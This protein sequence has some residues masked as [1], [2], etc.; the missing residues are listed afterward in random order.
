MGAAKA[1]SS[2]GPRALA[3]KSKPTDVERTKGD[4][5]HLRGGLTAALLDSAPG[6][7][8]LDQRVAKF[9]GIYQ[10]E[11][12]DGRA[13][14]RVTGTA[15]EPNF[16]VRVA[17][18]AGQLTADQY[19]ALDELAEDVVYNR[20]F[21]VTTRQDVQLHGVRKADLA[22]A[23][24][25]INEVGLTTLGGCGDVE[26]N[27]V[28]PPAPIRDTG[29]RAL[30]ALASDLAQAL[31]PAT[32]AYREIWLGDTPSDLAGE[33]EPLYGD[34]YLPRKFKTGLALPEDNSVDVHAQD[35]G[36]IGV[37]EAGELTGANVLVGGGAGLT[38]RRPETYARLASP[39]GFVARPYLV[40]TV[41]VVAGM[42]RDYGDRTDRRHSRLKYV[43][44]EWGIEAFRREFE[45]RASFPLEEWVETGPLE[46]RDWLGCHPQGD[47]RWLYG[48][49]V[50]NGRILDDGRRR[51]K[52]ALRTLVTTLRPRVAFTAQ[53]NLLLADLSEEDLPKVEQILDAYR[54]PRPDRLSFVRRHALAC[55][56]LPTCGL[57]LA[58][59]ERVAGEVVDSFERAFAA[60]GLD[61]VPLTLRMTGCPNGCTRPYSA[62]LALVGRK[63]GH[64]D[65]YLGGGLQG[66]RLAELYAESVPLERLVA[67]LEPLLDD[68]QR[69]RLPK[70][71]LGDFYDRCLRRALRRDILTGAKA[72]ASG[73]PSDA[74]PDDA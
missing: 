53:Q 48:V 61:D 39:L 5:R 1:G 52:S 15:R 44:E 73:L 14:A 6:L 37:V 46:H 7:D 64:Y 45:S 12:R 8:H 28:A 36:L 35:V 2:V 59:S 69:R 17:V 54:I 74:R 26:R 63:A 19:L 3:R 56:A 33:E 24:R 65:V 62:D 41:K 50:E 32:G 16:M 27:V 68:W 11:D 30:Q 43:V 13:L 22:R 66:A 51:W 42:F 57:A 67:R 38:H 18:P 29:H 23:I 55:P 47:G 20:G 34:A 21:R 25:R 49:Y 4:S 72:E 10:Q 71:G 70:E 40:E 60:R 9:H 31:A 58:E